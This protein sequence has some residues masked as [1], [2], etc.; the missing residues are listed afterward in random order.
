MQTLEGAADGGT[1]A[2]L[3]HGVLGVCKRQF[4]TDVG[5]AETVGDVVAVEYGGEEAHVVAVGALEA[6]AARPL[7][8]LGWVSS[9]RSA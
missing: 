7:T 2:T 9:L 3:L 5:I 4:C 6:G 1:L 8:C